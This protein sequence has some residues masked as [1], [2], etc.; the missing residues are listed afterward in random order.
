MTPFRLKIV[1]PDKI[2]FDGETEQIIVRTTEGDVGIL[3]N[4][5]KYVANLPVGYLKIKQEDGSFKMAAISSGAISV[6]DN[7]VTILVST[8][9]WADEIDVER[10]KRAEEVAREIIKNK[11]SSKEIDRA[12]LKLKRALNRINVANNK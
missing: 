3:A 4:H 1:A 12:N 10:A 2:F 6:G 11:E 7:L 9:E 5:A 8:I